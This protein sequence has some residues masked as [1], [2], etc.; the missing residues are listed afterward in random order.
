MGEDNQASEIHQS[1]YTKARQLLEEENFTKAID[2]AKAN[3]G[4]NPPPIWYIR[5]CILIVCAEDDWD[6]AECY[7]S[8]A[9]YVWNRA[10]DLSD[11]DDVSSLERRLCDLRHQLDD[12]ASRRREDEAREADEA[13]VNN[14]EVAEE[15]VPSSTRG[16]HEASFNTL[17]VPEE[18]VQSSASESGSRSRGRPR[19]KGTFVFRCPQQRD[20]WWSVSQEK[21]DAASKTARY[22][23]T[24]AGLVMEVNGVPRPGGALFWHIPNLL[25][26]TEQSD[27]RVIL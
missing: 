23:Y 1:L 25:D 20:A 5:N 21:F 13:P 26:N 19:G 3:I 6:K 22:R 27:C 2:Q 17:E 7:R 4:E 11:E 18:A 10:K 15:T 9:E 14:P 8:S 24:N 12:I 16:A